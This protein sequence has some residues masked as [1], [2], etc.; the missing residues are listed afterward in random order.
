MSDTFVNKF[1]FKL[2]FIHFIRFFDIYEGNFNYLA[3]IKLVYS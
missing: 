2:I 3:W 1:K